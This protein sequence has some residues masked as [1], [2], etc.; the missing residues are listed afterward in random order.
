VA[1]GL[2]DR[3]LRLLAMQRATTRVLAE[4]DTLA[5]GIPRVLQAICETL[6]WDHGAVWMLD[7]D[8]AVLRFVDLWQAPGSRFEQFAAVS[9][10]TEFASGVG[11]PGRVW[12]SA[13]PLWLA[14]VVVDSNFPRAPVARA[15]G[16]H[17]AFGFPILL[18]GEVHG[19]LEFFSREIREP[20]EELLQSLSAVGAQVG[21]FIERKHAEAGL[22]R[23]RRELDHFFTLSPDML[24]IGDFHG[25][26]QRV[27]PAWEKTLGYTVQELVSRS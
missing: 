7:A 6:G 24:C 3:E 27:N 1:E 10:A 15:E 5:D 20:D 2:S 4:A 18:E 26:F 14:D 16:L 21:Q 13:A 22:D 19:V 9:R 25:C 11:L 8:R 12:S 17:G 23:A